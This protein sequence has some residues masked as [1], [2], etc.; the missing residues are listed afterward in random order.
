M[1]A[2]KA[3]HLS[4]PALAG[5]DAVQTSYALAKVLETLEYDLVITGSE[6]TD[7]AW[8]S[9]RRCSPSAPAAA[10]VRRPQG[11]R[12]GR[13]R[14]HRAADRERLRRRRGR[15]ARDRLRRRE[16][17]RAALPVV[18]GD[19]GGQEEAAHDADARRRRH[20]RGQVGIA[21]APSQVASFS[22]KPPRQAGQVVKDEGDGGV[23]IAEY[24]ASQ[25][26][27]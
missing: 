12:R 18:Q 6:A 17:Q 8:R 21:V 11:H 24:L 7:S 16:D 10:A 9:C 14:P 27:V 20:R 19:H 4:D 23:K 13:Q 22:N 1:G 15:D 5:S 25:K 26:L 3:V 2:D